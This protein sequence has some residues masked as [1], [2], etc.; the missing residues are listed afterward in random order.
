MFHMPS[1][2]FG[3]IRTLV[4]SSFQFKFSRVYIEALILLFDV[5]LDLYPC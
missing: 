1:T 4:R 3:D 2:E 5:D